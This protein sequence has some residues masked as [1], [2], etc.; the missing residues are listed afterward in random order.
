MKGNIVLLIVTTVA[1][2]VAGCLTQEQAR[3][4][5]VGDTTDDTGLDI[6]PAARID[7]IVILEAP[8]EGAPGDDL[9]VC[10]EI[11]GVGVADVTALYFD[12]RSHAD[13]AFGPF[14]ATVQD[15]YRL[16][17]VFPNNTDALAEGGYATNTAYCA[18]VPMIEDTLYMRAYAV[19][20]EPPGELS[21]EH[22]VGVSA[23][24]TIAPNGE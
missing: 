14:G 2:V 9:F 18:F 8:D 15:H 22:E 4:H 23:E 7:E 1:L 20:D 21:E 17:F 12:N 6:A 13:E 16:G 19:V 24:F 10:W 5:G 11:R 3:D